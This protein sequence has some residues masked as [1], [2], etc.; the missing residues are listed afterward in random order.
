[1]AADLQNNIPSHSQPLIASSPSLDTPPLIDS[2]QLSLLIASMMQLTQFV[3]QIIQMISSQH[4]ITPLRLVV[5]LQPV[6][7]SNSCKKLRFKAYAA[8]L[9]SATS[10]EGN[11][12][13]SEGE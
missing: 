13:D 7:P 4:A 1:M 9:A 11:S 3:S 5:T 10:P 12:S 8:T 6:T 2:S